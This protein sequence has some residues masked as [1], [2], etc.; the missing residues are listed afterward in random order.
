MSGSNQWDKQTAAA[1]GDFDGNTINCEHLTKG[2]FQVIWAGLDKMDGRFAIESSNDAINW[3]EETE[4]SVESVSG[5]VIYR[6]NDIVTN[7][8]RVSVYNGTN[9]TGAYKIIFFGRIR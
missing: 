3:S 7:Y 5:N 1:I 2:S 4:Y 8:M 9:T 6:M